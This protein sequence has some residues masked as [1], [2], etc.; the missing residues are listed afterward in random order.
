MLWYGPRKGKKTKKK[1]KK[2]KEKVQFRHPKW[3]WV[4]VV[5]VVS[6]TFLHH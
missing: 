5:D 1:K 3:S 4:A 6:D 2:K